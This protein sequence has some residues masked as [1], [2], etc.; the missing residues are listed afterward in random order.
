MIAINHNLSAANVANTLT[1]HYGRLQTSTQRLSSGLRI[2]GAADDAAGLAIRELMRAD[3]S[4]LHQGMRNV[5]DA[6]SMIQTFDGALS[7]IDEKLI[8]MKE[9]AEQAA[10]GT[11][12]STQRLMIDSEFQ[13]MGSEIDRIA[14]ATDFNGVKLLCTKMMTWYEDVTKFRITD[15]GS[16][17][18]LQL[19]AGKTG[20]P[21]LQGA[22]ANNYVNENNPTKTISVS[23]TAEDSEDT[24]TDR[25]IE[26]SSGPIPG[27]PQGTRTEYNLADSDFTIANTDALG[28]VANPVITYN[29]ATGLWTMTDD[30]GDTFTANPINPGD[31]RLRFVGQGANMAMLDFSMTGPQ[32]VVDFSTFANDYDDIKSISIDTKNNTYTIIRETVIIDPAKNNT[33]DYTVSYNHDNQMVT[34][35]LTNG[36]TVS[37]KLD[38]PLADGDTINFDIN[39]EGAVTTEP[40]ERHGVD[41]NQRVKIHF[42]TMNDSAEDYYYIKYANCT[43]DGLGLSDVDI[44]TQDKAQE[45][46]VQINDAI[47]KK[48]KIRADYG[49]MQNRLENTLSNLSIQAENLQAAESRISDTEVAQEMMN[50][51]RYQILSQSAVAMLAQANNVPQMVMRLI[52]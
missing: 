33:Q 48:D 36:G 21:V 43:L 42:G 47:V 5:N 9:L 32:G 18:N 51:V 8:R 13:A 1:S 11:Y 37:M 28:T 27:N 7:V 31:T 15:P 19:P 41:P 38:N 39:F 49:A 46:L 50:F 14:N 34:V 23:L 29:K 20:T 6:I 40:E 25:L 35:R 52:G 26:I 45:A 4:A 16:I 22:N 24:N 2:N 44:Q 12:D 10:T 3:I 17:D 30:S